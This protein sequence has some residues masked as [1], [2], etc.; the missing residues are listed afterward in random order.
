MNISDRIK[1]FFRLRFAIL[2]PLAVVFAFLGSTNEDSIRQGL[3]LIL[4]G[5]LLRLW[6]NCY[7]VKTEKLTTCGPY[8]YL[9]NPLYLGTLLILTGAVVLTRIY[10]WG[11]VALF[12]FTIAYIRTIKN[13]ERLL[14]GIYQDEYRDYKKNVPSVI[15]RLTPYAKGEKWSFSWER[16]LR[17]KEHKV[18]IWIAITVIAFYLKEE[19]YMEKESFRIGFAY[20]IGVAVLLAVLDILSEVRIKMIKGV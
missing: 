14:E 4:P 8:A 13:E 15:P 10:L 9:R 7:A 17:S 3:L 16:L 19:L 6:S 1:R 2:Y 18:F 11:G 12:A 20:L 5:V